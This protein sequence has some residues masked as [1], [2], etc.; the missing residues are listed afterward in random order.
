[1]SCSAFLNW[2]RLLCCIVLCCTVLLCAILYCISSRAISLF[3][4][5]YR[6]DRSASSTQRLSLLFSFTHCLL[7]PLNIE[8][9]SEFMEVVLI[10]WSDWLTRTYI[11]HFA[12]L[13]RISLLCKSLHNYLHTGSWIWLSPLPVPSP[14]TGQRGHFSPVQTE[15]R[16]SQLDNSWRPWR[17][18]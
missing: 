5:V 10:F 11:M 13:W 14:P 4:A 2:I 18:L 8:Q 9:Y 15:S 3:F 7:L 17:N 6:I 1:M 16:S 12:T